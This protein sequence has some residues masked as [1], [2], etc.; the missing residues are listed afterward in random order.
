MCGITGFLSNNFSNYKKMEIIVSNMASR[1][2]HRGPD[3]YGAWVDGDSIIA[4]GHRRLSILDLSVSGHQPMHSFNKRYVI[5]FNGEIYNHLEIR[6]KINKE[7][8]KELLWRGHSDTETLLMAFECWGVEQTLRK[9]VGMFAIA[10]WDRHKHLLTLARDR[11]GEKPLYYGW[12]N[13]AFVFGSELKALRAYPNFN[14]QICRKALA[15]YLRFNYVPTPLSI[16]KDIYKL[17]PGNFIEVYASNFTKSEI[18]SKKYWSLSAQVEIGKNE[19]ILSESE[20]LLS[21]EKCLNKSVSSQMLADVPLGAFLSG[22]IDSST[23]VALMQQQSSRPVNTFTL[24]FEES[25]FDE[26][27]YARAVA[28][29]LGTDHNELII[30]HNEAKTLLPQLPVIYDEPFADASQIPTY[31]LSQLARKKV[32]V[33][34]S[35]DGGDELFGG[36]DRYTLFP[37]I[38]NKISWLPYAFRKLFGQSVR[39]LPVQFWDNLNAISKIFLSTKNGILGDRVH[40]MGQRLQEI[41]SYEEF[42]ISLT[43]GW[44]YPQTLIK[45]LIGHPKTLQP[46]DMTE[47][48][49]ELQDKVALLMYR[50]SIYFLPDDILCKV[51]RAAMA[52]SL[53]TRAPFLDHRVVELA[54]KMPMNMKIR[55]NQGKWALRQIL[56]R[57][58]PRELIERPKVGFAIPLDQ[59]LRGPLRNWVTSLLDHDR[60]QHE[61]FFHPELVSKIWK[62][63]LSGKYNWSRRLW[64]LVM[65]Q[66][67][68]EQQK[69]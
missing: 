12:V 46:F 67:W 9:C 15:N 47:L 7:S 50:D 69:Q 16:Y 13:D 30:T 51:D 43:I 23:I 41:K 68:L 66:A 17:E 14:N 27:P 57:Y 52:N 64:S 11:I 35:G 26:S 48:D 45:D 22:G 33:A 62:Q 3:D 4:L 42:C 25:E 44:D 20:S 54:W 36:Y 2:M 60:L 29:H 10:L 19:L 53:E 8:N 40:R 39:I 49:L 18:S 37:E 5:S 65:F 38:W 6:K 59:W 1:L 24:G 55:N 63:H 21:L 32:T 31:F 58:V 61:G 28:K 34:L 56:Y